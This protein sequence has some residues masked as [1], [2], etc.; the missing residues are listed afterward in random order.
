M[1]HL[2][3]WGDVGRYGEIWGRYGVAPLGAHAQQVDQL[4][5]VV[6]V[7]WSG[8]G[9][10]VG[11]GVRVGV[12][13]GVG[14]RVRVRVRVRCSGRAEGSHTRTCVSLTGQYVRSRLW[15]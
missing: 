2:E 11:V 8:V 1:A 5:V 12:G 4:E 3:I 14:V 7:S 6:E 13:V 9:L 15:W 10:G